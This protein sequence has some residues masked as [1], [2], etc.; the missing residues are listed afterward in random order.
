MRGGAGYTSTPRRCCAKPWAWAARA[1]GRLL[2]WAAIGLVLIIAAGVGVAVAHRLTVKAM[3]RR[4][5]WST[6]MG[7]T[8][9]RG[10]TAWRNDTATGSMVLIV[11]RSSPMGPTGVALR[12]GVK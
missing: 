7:P 8:G 5:L 3:V 9:R 12:V 11:R 10:Y 2:R 6:L 1:R 4:D